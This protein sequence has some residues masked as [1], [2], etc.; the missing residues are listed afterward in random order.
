MAIGPYIWGVVVGAAAL[1][2]IGFT[3]G[4]WYTAGGAAKAIDTALKPAVENFLPAVCAEQAKTDPEM[5]AK[6]AAVAEAAS[7]QKEAAFIKTGWVNI[8]KYDL[9]P[10]NMSILAKACM[11]LVIPPPAE[12]A[13]TTPG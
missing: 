6:L 10:G 1:A 2:I 13:N 8:P 3:W 5:A 11:P 4:G 7:Y 12:A 9:S